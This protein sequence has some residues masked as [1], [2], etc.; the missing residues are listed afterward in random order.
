MAEKKIENFRSP[1]VFAS[2]ATGVHCILQKEF[3]KKK[4]KT[5]SVFFLLFPTCM[6]KYDPMYK[7]FTCMQSVKAAVGKGDYIPMMG[8]CSYFLHASITHP[9]G[10]LTSAL[11]FA[12]AST[13]ITEFGF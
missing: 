11:D 7:N 5:H 2:K 6:L 12:H 8:A 3:K 9:M 4:K 13:G 10:P 1:H